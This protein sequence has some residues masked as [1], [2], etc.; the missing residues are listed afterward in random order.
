MTR[1]I[2]LTGPAGSGKTHTLLQDFEKTLRESKDPLA[3]DFFF[4]LPS[5]EHTER[6]TTLILQRQFNGFFHRRVTTLS[7]LI[8]MLF[9]VGE[10]GTATNVTRFLLL[11]DLLAAEPQG[12]FEEVQE[13]PGF[14]NLLLGFVSEIKESLISPELFRERMNALKRLEPDLSV[15]Y[16]KLAALY[17]QYEKALADKGLRDRQDALKIYRER[18]KSPPVPVRKIKKI[19]I[20]GFFDFSELQAA[21]L[22][23]L[24]EMAEE[25]VITLTVDPD[26]A[27]Q[28]LFEMVHR[29]EAL[30]TAKGFVKQ[31]LG[32][33][34][35]GNLP[36]VLAGVEKHLF[37]T[38]KP[39]PLLKP[40]REL[41]VF[42]AIGVEGEVEMIA[43]TIEH[44][45]RQGSFR[46]SDFAILLRNIGEYETVIRSIFGRYG[47]PVEIHERERLSFAPMVP[48]IC[49]LL[50]IFRDG[51]KLSDLMAFL[52]SGYVRSLG[53]QSKDYEWVS[54][55]EH[56]AL[57]RK[58]LEGRDAWL[59]GWDCG[60]P[61]EAERIK[62]LKVLAE[63]ED[64]LRSALS[65]AA[66]KAALRQAVEEVFGIF[67]VS[68]S[69]EEHVRR[70]AASHRR[71]LSLLDEVEISAKR[72]A[73]DLN[74]FADRF[75]R[76]VEL[77][78]YSLHDHD[79]NRVQVYNVS[80]ARQKEY[81]VVFI[82]GLLEKKFPVQIK[83]DPLLSDWERKLFNGLGP[84]SHLKERL[85]SQSLERYLFYIAVT[86]ARHKLIL[87]Y[88]RLD[89][90]GKESLPSFYV[91]EIR[92][93]FEGKLPDRKQKLARPFPDLGDAV[94][95]RELETSV[96]GNLWEPLRKGESADPLLLEASA[97]LLENE[98]SRGRL[99][100]AF[101]EVRNELTD[102]AIL[103]LKVFRAEET[104]S[105][106]LEEYAKCA[107]KYYAHRVLKLDD[108]EE[109]KNVM[110]R[111]IV[112]HEALEF[113]FRNW[114]ERPAVLKDPARA[115]A[116]A[117]HY[118]E[119][120]LKRHPILSSRRYQYALEIE[121]LRGTLVKFLENELERLRESPLKPAFF[122]LGF[123]TQGAEYPPLVIENGDQKV[124]IRGK[125]DRIDLDEA[126]K[127][128]LVLDYKRSISFS[129]DA[130]EMGTALQ[131]PVYAMVLERLLGIPL[132]GAE[133]YSL[134]DREKKGFYREEQRSFL[135]DLSS[136]SR[137]VLDDNSYQALIVRVEAFIRKFT[138]DRTDMKIPVRPRECQD[139][140]PYTTVCRIEKWKLKSMLE[141]IRAED[142]RDMPPLIP[143]GQ[144]KSLAGESGGEA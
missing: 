120:A 13:T 111:G 40:S 69:S 112:L 9:G 28:E 8:T 42:E 143:A 70:D 25:V 53:K 48:V 26:P 134:R 105:T 74:A 85:S 21:Y 116:E 114:V 121:D 71:F 138:K 77:D 109:E 49:S 91:E 32:R 57:R 4:V 129:R 72:E 10:E 78:L 88:P 119:Q 86:R 140:C 133:L 22:E 93:L 82:A 6:I 64:R 73:L 34:E 84:G 44:L 68:D 95:L 97:R 20:D 128:G 100:R 79:R 18:R 113:A 101:F 125:I 131:L 60:E 123:G 17:E 29:T 67:Q 132:A 108:P 54:R 56:E 122:E 135:P 124:Q 63:V 58:V 43:R 2:L 92:V 66:Q 5:A 12:Y 23:E 65:S 142:A 141:E 41:T 16:E 61:F 118:L 55:L 94:N 51:W 90:E 31:E 136:R 137:M 98:S 130:L 36:A 38:Q 115:S 107:F 117:L 75:F 15:K 27:R 144:D 126:R 3:E 89:L 139:F 19:W 96:I 1:K 81:E 52:K 46:F 35:E 104:S 110:I 127:A 45:Q 62:K 103:A 14:L 76:L 47:I 87:S 106:S 7:R 24:C 39:Q 80:L 99:T 11:R 59:S 30:L 102:P 37:S 33:R 83:E 50:R